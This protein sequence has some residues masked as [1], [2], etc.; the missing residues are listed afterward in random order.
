MFMHMLVLVRM[1]VSMFTLVL[2]KFSLP[3]FC[4]AYLQPY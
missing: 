2:H 4:L 1:V 3:V